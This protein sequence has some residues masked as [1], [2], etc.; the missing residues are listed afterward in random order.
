M[1]RD[2]VLAAGAIG[3]VAFALLLAAAAPGVLADPT[4]DGPLRPGPVEVAEVAIA[5]GA[6]SGETADLDVRT[7]LRHRGNPAPNVSVRFRA[8]D[9]ESGLVATERTVRV[10]NLTRDGEVPANA[11]LTVEREGSY[12]IET[13]VYRGAERVD[14]G[15]KSVDGLEALTPAYAESSVAFTER[16][17]VPAMATSVRGTTGNRTT[18]ALSA[19]LTNGGATVDDGLRVTVTLRQADSNLVADRASVDVGSIREGRT[20]TVT[21]ELTVPTGYN[22]YADAVLWKEGVVVD[23]TRSAV[24]LDPTERV[25]VNETE[26]DVELR[27][28][29]FERTDDAPADAEGKTAGERPETAASQPGFGAGLTVLA[30]LVSLGAA[31]FARRQEDE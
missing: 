9:V 11:T 30:L 2:T 12:R 14:A 23:T 5:P 31:P 18:L 6:V 21:A 28:S 4:D 22:Y 20:E 3:V 27:V 19:S 16:D 7:R 25:S 17:T 8:V 13:V 10:G 24:N 15:R 1:N 29:D 26:R